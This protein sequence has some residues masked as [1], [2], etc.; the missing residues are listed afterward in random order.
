MTSFFKS[1]RF[2]MLLPV[3]TMT[4]FVVSLLTVLFSRAYTNMIV[5][6]EQEENAA[7]FELISRSV[8]PLI[9]T[10]I[11]QVRSIMSDDRVASYARLRY[12]SA[13]EL[14]HARIGCRDY[15][16]GEISRLD[17]I[18][19][20]LFMRSDGSLFGT[21]PEGNF[22]LD[23]PSRNPLPGEMTAQILA[24]PLGQ[25]VWAGPVSGEEIYGFKNSA[26]PQNIMIAAWKTVDVS[27]GDLY[28]L[29]LMDDTIFEK[30][31]SALQDENSTWHLF[32]AE[33]AE[34]FHTGEDPCAD[35]GRLI[36]ESNSGTVFRNE[37]GEPVSAFSMRMTSPDWT[38][39]REVSMADS[40]QVVRR[41]RSTVMILAA[42][43]FLI[44]LAI[45]R[46]WHRGFMRQFNSLLNG[47]IRMGQGELEPTRSEPYTIGEF[48]TMQRE[49][50]RTSLALNEQ[51]E[52]IRR[53]EREQM[54]QENR[55]REQEAIIRELRMAREIQKNAL[56]HTFPPFPERKE[57][58]LYASMDPAR[59]I[60]GDFYDYFFVDD[61]HL[62]LLIADVSGKGI[63]AALFMMDAKRTLED[64][65]RTDLSV[66]E[67]LEKTNEELCGGGDAEMFV[68]V[69]IGILEIST[70]RLSAANAGHE[71]PAICGKDGR[72]A[73]YKDKHGFV[74]GG[75][76][77]VRY[78]EYVLQLS[79]GDRIFVYTDGVPEATAVSGEMF[80]TDRMIGALN[81]CADGSPEEILRCV[82]RSV[83][84]FAGEAEQFDDLTM[85]CFEYRGPQPAASDIAGRA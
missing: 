72:F 61:D 23:D 40:E 5:Q 9:D 78:G 2:R 38:L 47:I 34:I 36:G 53:M 14:I 84:A 8:T 68:T 12:S 73:L 26:T 30:Q 6:R 19:G 15:L 62:C 42:V 49:I 39:V 64:T 76:K 67:I 13:A 21:L 48:E 60:G 63:P 71:Y 16:R 41:T 75:M 83:D 31:F 24:A 7:G 55:R 58:E 27:Y 79:P 3:I 70:G 59:D 45:Y 85:L 46:S 74:L 80:G 44:A 29:M 18:F 1:L 51:M 69:W 33:N 35:P 66:S 57:I 56:P 77:G 20:L 11:G 54:E 4:L 17:G 50:D 25:T 81:T 82:R 10:S 65:A 22:F 43:I 28:A 32:T 37:N 52:T